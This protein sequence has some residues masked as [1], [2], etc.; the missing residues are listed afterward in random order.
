MLDPKIPAARIVVKTSP[1]DVPKWFIAITR[2]GHEVRSGG[3]HNGHMPAFPVREA[4]IS[5]F[6]VGIT[7]NIKPNRITTLRFRCSP[8]ALTSLLSTCRV[9]P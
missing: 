8:R 1:A 6:G 5:P 2:T 7:K 3:A 9:K 4:H